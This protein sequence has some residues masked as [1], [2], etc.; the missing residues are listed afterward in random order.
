MTC[1]GKIVID[2]TRLSRDSGL[3]H[4]KTIFNNSFSRKYKRNRA[5]SRSLSRRRLLLLKR[6]HSLMHRRKSR[7]H[8]N[9]SQSSRNISVDL[10]RCPCS[11][12]HQRASKALNQL[13]VVSQL[14]L[15]LCLSTLSNRG[16][17]RSRQWSCSR[18][19]I[20]TWWMRSSRVS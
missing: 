13:R 11:L 20:S 14:T 6:T 9:W 17:S 5:G 1:R 7:R 8:K 15:Q 16:N 4:P 2:Y 10:L 18:S 12:S 19:R 3:V